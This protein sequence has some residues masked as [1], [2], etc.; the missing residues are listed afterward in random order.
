MDPT[1]HQPAID[2]GAESLPTPSTIPGFRL[3]FSEGGPGCKE[4]ACPSVYAVSG[5]TDLLIQGHTLGE[6]RSTLRIPNNEDVVRIPRA[7]V[8]MIVAAVKAG[9]L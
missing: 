3:L 6:D 2:L 9:K 4:G 8:D 7:L 5:S 1:R